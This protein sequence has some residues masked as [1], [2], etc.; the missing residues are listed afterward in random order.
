[1]KRVDSGFTFRVAHHGR[2]SFEVSPVAAQVGGFV[3]FGVKLSRPDWSAGNS[4]R[5]DADQLRRG[6]GGNS[7]DICLGPIF[8]SHLRHEA[9][10]QLS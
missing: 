6:E 8:V 1:M 9:I 10:G 3:Q 5:L 2:I 7:G 4:D